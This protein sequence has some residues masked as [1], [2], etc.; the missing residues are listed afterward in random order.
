MFHTVEFDSEDDPTKLDETTATKRLSSMLTGDP[1]ADMYTFEN[2]ARKYLERSEK[3]FVGAS[4]RVEHDSVHRFAQRQEVQLASRDTGD[5]FRAHERDSLPLDGGERAGV[6]P[7]STTSIAR[8]ELPRSTLTSLEGYKTRDLFASHARRSKKTRAEVVFE[9]SNDPIGH[10]YRTSADH[11]LAA[12]DFP[13]T[14]AW[15]PAFKIA[16]PPEDTDTQLGLHKFRATVDEKKLEAQVAALSAQ[17]MERRLAAQTLKRSVM[18]QLDDYAQSQSRREGE[19][20]RR[21]EDGYRQLFDQQD[22][23]RRD[24]KTRPASAPLHLSASSSKKKQRSGEKSDHAPN[25]DSH[26]YGAPLSQ[27]ELD[28]R[29][30]RT[31]MSHVDV[32]LLAHRAEADRRAA[33]AH[34]DDTI[35]GNGVSIRP[36]TA[37]R[38]RTARWSDANS[39][40][41]TASVAGHVHGPGCEHGHFAIGGAPPTSTATATEL[42][43]RHRPGSAALQQYESRPPSTTIIGSTAGMAPSAIAALIPAPKPAPLPVPVPLIEHHFRQEA[44]S[45][46][47]RSEYEIDQLSH[48]MSTLMPSAHDVGHDIVSDEDDE[49]T[50]AFE[51]SIAGATAARMKHEAR[52][53]EKA[54]RI[55]EARQAARQA[56]EEARE[57]LKYKTEVWEAHKLGI[58]PLDE[59]EADHTL[60][61]VKAKR[62]MLTRAGVPLS[63]TPTHDVAFNSSVV[64]RKDPP[65]PKARVKKEGAGGAGTDRTAAST[66]AS[67]KRPTSSNKKGPP[68]IKAKPATIAATLDKAQALQRGQENVDFV[69]RL[70]TDGQLADTVDRISA[71]DQL[72]GRTLHHSASMYRSNEDGKTRQRP[73]PFSAIYSHQSATGLQLAP[74]D[75]TPALLSLAPASSTPS[76]SSSSLRPSTA[77][78]LGHSASHPQLLKTPKSRASTIA[79]LLTHVH[80]HV[81]SSEGML[82]VERV[83]EAMARDGHMHGQPMRISRAILE[84]AL[85]PPHVVLTPAQRSALPEQINNLATNPFEVKKKK[86]LKKGRKGSSKKKKKSSSKKKVDGKKV[87]EPEGLAFPLGTATSEF[88]GNP[89]VSDLGL[90]NI[91][92]LISTPDEKTIF[93]NLYLQHATHLMLIFDFYSTRGSGGPPLMSQIKWLQFLALCHVFQPSVS[94]ST[95][96]PAP[97]LSPPSVTRREALEIFADSDDLSVE[98]I[99]VDELISRPAFLERLARIAVAK[100][101]RVVTLPPAPL[102]ESQPVQPVPLTPPQAFETFVLKYLLPNALAVSPNEFRMRLLEEKVQAVLQQHNIPLQVRHWSHQLGMWDYHNRVSIFKSLFLRCLGLLF[103]FIQTMF[104][105]YAHASDGTINYDSLKQL[106]KECDIPPSAGFVDK[107]IRETCHE[108]G[109]TGDITRAHLFYPDLMELFARMSDLATPSGDLSIGLSSFLQNAW[110]SFTARVPSANSIAASIAASHQA[111]AAVATGVSGGSK[112]NTPRDTRVKFA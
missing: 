6:G 67:A 103:H 14:K 20:I 1:L 30:P 10:R 37:N 8:G 100:C 18:N 26:P 17:H 106:L 87:V 34:G 76:S 7:G 65:P 93:R 51:D 78:L 74:S 25:G 77:S 31:A 54:R 71:S 73:R 70:Y 55:E 72:Y 97:S 42:L 86:K 90:I 5:Y 83:K 40:P 107:A 13:A 3:A 63:K 24:A 112:T 95:A 108:I 57:K 104:S 62:L 4:K 48:D 47:K 50:V 82:V 12:S 49:P 99:D 102:G 79:N 29:D 75:G 105:Q 15:D 41:T 27:S 89:L 32:Q 92:D 66:S 69:E 59:T 68:T 35:D 96:S 91:N 19:T 81:A 43:H 38:L 52:K 64:K 85:I 94:S 110:T 53:A 58:M 80:S 111:A 2:E 16:N 60:A 61:A 36:S 101:G 56:R 22:N 44:W 109:S 84:H 33:N 45:T 9:A 46:S 88:A 21:S 28:K 11:V 98:N 39:N 23:D